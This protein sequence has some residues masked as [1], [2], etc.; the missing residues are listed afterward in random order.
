MS[1]YII[2]KFEA[3]ASSTWADYKSKI[4]QR[5]AIKRVVCDLNVSNCILPKSNWLFKIFI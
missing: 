2:I 1:T 5:N 4:E 3:W